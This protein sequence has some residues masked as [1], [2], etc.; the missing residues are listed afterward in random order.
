MSRLILVSARLAVLFTSGGLLTGGVVQKEES[1][2]IMGTVLFLTL[3]FLS[4]FG[5]YKAAKQFHHGTLQPDD[6]RSLLAN[7]TKWARWAI[8]FGGLG[9]S[10]AGHPAGLLIWS[11]VVVCYL[12]S[13]EIF[14]HVTGVPLRMGYGGWEFRRPPKRR[15]RH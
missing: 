8:V 7:L 5:D 13:G 6:S 12:L 10:V 1:L 4:L 9:L 2:W 14:Q 15:R 11:G 3:E